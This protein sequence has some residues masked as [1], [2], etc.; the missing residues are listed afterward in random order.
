MNRRRPI[1]IVPIL[2]ILL[3][4]NTVFAM[5]SE[6]LLP[7]EM[8]IHSTLEVLKGAKLYPSSTMLCGPS[9]LYIGTRCLHK[10]EYSLDE[11]ARMAEWDHVEG[12]T[13]LGLETACKKMGLYGDAFKL[14]VNRLKDL[15]DA[16]SALAIIEHQGHYFLLL[17]AQDSR[18]LV[19]TTPHIKPYWLEA[20]ILKKRWN[21]RALLFSKQPISV[22]HTAGGLLL[23]VGFT[24][25]FLIAILGTGYFWKKS[26]GKVQNKGTKHLP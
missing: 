3:S 6:G 4:L 15:M 8:Q 5:K 26:S 19:V 16:N 24:G 18:F 23:L 12:T 20:N 1:T 10:E 7:S 9:L 11:I 25:F 17:K 14:S 22:N 21:R 13:L 2:L